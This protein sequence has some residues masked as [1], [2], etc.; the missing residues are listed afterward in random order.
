VGRRARTPWWKRAS[1]E[2]RALEDVAD[3]EIEA[4]SADDRAKLAAIWQ[5]RGG[6]ELRV[7]SGFSS[8]SVEL[9]EHGTSPAVYELVTQAVRDEVHHAEISIEMAARYRG[10]RPMWPDPEPSHLPPFAP[11]TGQMHATLFVIAQCCINETVACGVL[12][13]AIAQSKSPLA[14]AAY[15]TILSDE[16]DHARAGWAHL[17][18]PFVTDEMRQELPDWLRHLHA[19]KMAE[20]VEDDSPLPGENYAS[21]GMLSRRRSREVVHATLLDVMLPG[22]RQARIDTSLLEEWTRGAFGSAEA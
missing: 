15:A 22:F 17:V 2:A 20:L 4:T 1:R 19:V 14:R 11:T 13:A 8:L 10:D 9:L 3:P 12:E 6:L 5:K 7:A 21:H 16:I 18:S